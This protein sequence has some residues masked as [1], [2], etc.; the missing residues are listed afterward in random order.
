MN[1]FD[2]R[3]SLEELTSSFH[4]EAKLKSIS[5]KLDYEHGNVSEAEDIRT[6]ET[7]LTLILYNLIS[8]SIRYSQSGLIQIKSRLLTLSEAKNRTEF[9]LSR[10]YGT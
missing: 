10:L 6:D 1:T 7:K 5:I 3:S 2:L 9:Y 8:N 4:Q